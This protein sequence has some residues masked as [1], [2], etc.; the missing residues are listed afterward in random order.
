MSKTEL[1]GVKGIDNGVYYE[2]WATKEGL[3][4]S[5]VDVRDEKVSKVYKTRFS[6]LHLSSESGYRVDE[7]DILPETMIKELAIRKVMEKTG[8]SYDAAAKLLC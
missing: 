2:L 4:W 7:K 5:F 6:V 8:K 3:G 1:I